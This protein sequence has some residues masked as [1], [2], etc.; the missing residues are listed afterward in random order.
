MKLSIAVDIFE[1]ERINAGI[2][3]LVKSGHLK[4]RPDS[5]LGR[6]I[7]AAAGARWYT[8][9]ELELVVLQMFGVADTQAAISA[10]LREVDP[11]RH[12]LKKERR[13]V[14]DPNS[15]KRVHFYRLVATERK[16]A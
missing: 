6:V 14:K 5:Q 1:S 13:A 15:G 3:G 7:H 11:Q 2:R 8:L 10:R 9:R 12:G 4:D 16:Y